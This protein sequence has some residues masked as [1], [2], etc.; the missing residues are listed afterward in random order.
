M[1]CSLGV[2]FLRSDCSRRL[3]ICVSLSPLERKCSMDSLSENPAFCRS[4]NSFEGCFGIFL[5]IFLF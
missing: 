3:S 1:S 4:D 5:F 2:C